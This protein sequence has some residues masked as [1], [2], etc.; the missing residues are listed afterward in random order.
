MS[1]HIWSRA[2]YLGLAVAALLTA[3]SLTGKFVVHS[4]AAPQAVIIELK[5][6][7]VVVAKAKAE[8]S[9]QQFDPIS[10]RQKLITEQN[11]FLGQLSAAGIN[12]SQVS[13][14][15]PNGPNG[16]VTRIQFRYN[17]VFNGLTLAVDSAAVETIR[18]MGAVKSV[19]NDEPITMQL[20]HA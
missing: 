8:A 17:Y 15:A 14:D 5:S 18:R 7:P 3:V 6:D 12:F 4:V 13:V 9:G 11:N 19:H 1:K 2:L 20:D 16:E 10:Y